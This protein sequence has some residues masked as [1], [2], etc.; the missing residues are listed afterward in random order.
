MGYRSH[1]HKKGKKSKPLSARD[2]KANKRKSAVRVRVD[3]V[4]G[5]ITNEQGGLYFRVIGLCLFSEVFKETGEKSMFCI[6]SNDDN[7]VKIDAC[8]A[9]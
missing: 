8:I 6:L 1:V 5:S 7:W 9:S 4:F 3:H 2:K